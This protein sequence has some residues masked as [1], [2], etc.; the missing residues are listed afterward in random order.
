M[1]TNNISSMEKLLKMMLMPLAL[2]VV[3]GMSLTSCSNDDEPEVKMSISEEYSG[4]Y[5]GKITLNVAGKY[6]YDADITCIVTSAGSDV[7]NVSIPEYSLS[8]TM[9]G[10][11]TLGSVSITGLV[12]DEAK[13]CFF[14]EYGGEGISQT[15]NGKSYPLN[16]PSSMQVVKD[17]NGT[18]IIDNP[19]TLGKMPLPLSARFEGSK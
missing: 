2:Y 12:Y 6:S 19:F 1:K 7:I 4:T 10:D 14:R 13:G 17:E 18:L 5:N 15:M 8:G 9:M 16:E 11:M 3:L